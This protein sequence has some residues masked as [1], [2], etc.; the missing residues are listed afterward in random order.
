VFTWF[1]QVCLAWSLQTGLHA[2]A[3]EG[4]DACGLYLGGQGFQDLEES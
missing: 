3:G 4:V 2:D 1:V